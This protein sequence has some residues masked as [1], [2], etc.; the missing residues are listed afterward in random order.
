LNAWQGIVCEN[1]LD[2]YLIAAWI[3]IEGVVKF[4]QTDETSDQDPQVVTVS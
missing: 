2:R 4:F 1:Q 3:L